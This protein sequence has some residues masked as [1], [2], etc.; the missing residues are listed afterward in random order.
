[1]FLRFALTA[2]REAEFEDVCDDVKKSATSSSVSSFDRFFNS[3]N[4]RFLPAFFPGLGDLDIALIQ[5][6]I[7]Y[8]LNTTIK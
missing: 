1:M 8:C 7:S 6:S 3:L 2:D 4:S 5:N